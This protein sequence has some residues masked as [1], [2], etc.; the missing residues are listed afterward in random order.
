M[1]I[2]NLTELG[3]TNF[4]QSQLT[5][6]SYES[7]LPF[8]VTTVQRNLIECIGFD[9]NGSLQTLQTSTYFWRDKAPQEH[10]TVGDWLMLNFD[11]SPLRLLERKTLIKRRSAGRESIIQISL[12]N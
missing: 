6:D 10:P 1:H 9:Q 7:E 3:W 11:L 4:Y 5:L 12:S 8:R 2:D